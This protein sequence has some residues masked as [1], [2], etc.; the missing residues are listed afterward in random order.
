MPRTL[1]ERNEAGGTQHPQHEWA[2]SWTRP[3]GL[4]LE[5]Q[6]WKSLTT[7][8]E[9]RHCQKVSETEKPKVEL[10]QRVT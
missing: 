10:G 1:S 4:P 5:D 3:T 6:S 9:E 8:H 7:G 2:G